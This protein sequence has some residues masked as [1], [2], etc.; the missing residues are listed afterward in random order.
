MTKAFIIYGSSG[1]NTE[2]VCQKVA[3][4]L[5]QAGI[6]VTLKRVEK[7]TPADIGGPPGGRASDLTILAAPTYE[8]GVILQH[9]QPFLKAL[10]SVDL[11]RQKITVIG[12]GEPQYDDHYHIESANTLTNAIKASGGTLFCHPL[13]VSGAVLPQLQSRV[14]I[15]AQE[16]ARNLISM[17]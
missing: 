13:R 16:L 10:R 3:E 6:E 7:S 15:W 17:L 14:T 8:H 2:L 4:V 12:L 11:S 9:W 5:E 1:G